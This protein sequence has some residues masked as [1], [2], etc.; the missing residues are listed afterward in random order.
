MAAPSSYPMAPIAWCVQ[1]LI[2]LHSILA[3]DTEDLGGR[4]LDDHDTPP[5]NAETREKRR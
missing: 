3:N 1:S 2:A 5:Q 4:T